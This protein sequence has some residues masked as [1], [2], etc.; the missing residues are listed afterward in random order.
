MKL[1]ITPEVVLMILTRIWEKSA[2]N[3]KTP[4]LVSC[5][6]LSNRRLILSEN[7]Y[8]V[9]EKISDGSITS[10]EEVAREKDICDESNIR[11]V[12]AAAVKL[13][14]L[15]LPTNGFLLYNKS[16][17]PS[18]LVAKKVEETIQEYW[19]EKHAYVVDKRKI[20]TAKRNYINDNDINMEQKVVVSYAFLKR[21]GVDITKWDNVLSKYKI[22]GEI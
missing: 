19:K 8:Y 18:M 13:G 9:A 1:E 4:R 14:Y 7:R 6:E 5:N 16:T 20:S 10:A 2:K 17:K 22:D 15:S 11:L 3:R 12:K 21:M